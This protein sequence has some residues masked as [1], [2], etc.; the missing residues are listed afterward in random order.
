MEIFSIL[1]DNMFFAII[2]HDDIK[3]QR[4]E[5]SYITRLQTRP[6]TAISHK[7]TC[8]RL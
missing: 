2:K 4:T 6:G 3:S 1:K 7:V 5:G 8:Q